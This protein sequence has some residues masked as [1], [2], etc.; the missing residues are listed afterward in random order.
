MVQALFSE[1]EVHRHIAQ[2]CHHLGRR[3]YVCGHGQEWSLP[4]HCGESSATDVPRW[5]ANLQT[6]RKGLKGVPMTTVWHLEDFKPE[7]IHAVFKSV[8]ELSDID[9]VTALALEKLV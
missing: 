6:C 5:E 9:E 1:S 4:C 3:G 2:R 7:A 8:Q